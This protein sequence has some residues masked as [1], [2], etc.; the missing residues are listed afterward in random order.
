MTAPRRL[1][2]DGERVEHVDR[3]G[4]YLIIRFISGRALLIHLRMTGSLRA[5]ALAGDSHRRALLTLDDGSQ[6]AYRDVRRFGTWLLLEPGGLG[7]YWERAWARSRSW[8]PSPQ[9]AWRP[10]AGASRRSEG[11][12]ARPADAGRAREH[13]RRRGAL[14]LQAASVAPRRAPSI[15]TSCG[16]YA[17]RSGR[18]SSS[19]SPARAPRSPT[20]GS[21]TE[22]RARCRRSSRPTGETTSRVTAGHADR[23]DAG[24]GPRHVVLPA[25]SGLP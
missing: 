23:Q 12:A 25:L 15:E 16:G 24:L 18:R 13:L 2:A 21:R 9:R 11:C 1:G 14:V 17:G 5:D 8:P 22:A 3:R 10:P 4:K 6:V 7:P 20:T 19:V